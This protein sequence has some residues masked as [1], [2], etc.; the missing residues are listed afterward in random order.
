MSPEQL[1]GMEVDARSD[2]YAAGVVLYE[3]VTGKLPFEAPTI[4]ALMAKH[5]EENPPDP[6]DSNPEV[7]AAFAA[8][9][10]RAMAKEP[11]G[12]YQSARELHDALEA[13]R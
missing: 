1:S 9:M 10:I 8:V 4:V 3:C 13:V 2:I 11:R 6:R 7:S 5:L 12:R